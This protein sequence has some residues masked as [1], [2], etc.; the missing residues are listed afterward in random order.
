MGVETIVGA[1]ATGAATY[2]ARKATPQTTTEAYNFG[3]PDPTKTGVNAPP[4]MDSSYVGATQPDATT[5]TND[6]SNPQQIKP[7]W[8]KMIAGLGNGNA[9]G[10]SMSSYLG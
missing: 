8:Q 7:P 4:K 3:G 10:N 1:L 2:A 9:N 6:A 5:Q